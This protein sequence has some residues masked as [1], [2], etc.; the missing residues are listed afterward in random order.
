MF[1]VSTPVIF[2]IVKCT[3]VR[4]IEKLTDYSYFRIISLLSFPSRPFL[5]QQLVILCYADPLK[6][7]WTTQKPLHRQLIA[8]AGYT[9]ETSHIMTKMNF[10]SLLIELKNLSSTKDSK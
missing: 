2:L 5:F 6:V 8:T 3:M 7:T 10:S 4:E 1:N 9:Q